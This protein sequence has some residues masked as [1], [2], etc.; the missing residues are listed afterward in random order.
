MRSLTEE[1]DRV[2]GAVAPTT[3]EHT[4][5]TSS[6]SEED[7]SED[8]EEQDEDEDV[9]TDL[10]R[11]D[12]LSRPPHGRHGR[13]RQDSYFTDDDAQAA[14]AATGRRDSQVRLTLTCIGLTGARYPPG[15][16]PM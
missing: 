6:Y 4:I 13:Q 10:P 14:T 15:Y 9:V 16:S 3:S 5:G 1:L 8:R 11:E 7:G 12:D 2:G